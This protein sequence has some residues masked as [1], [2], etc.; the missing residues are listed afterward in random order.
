MARKRDEKII[1]TDIDGKEMEVVI[2]IG[3]DG[4]EIGRTMRSN[5]D[6]NNGSNGADLLRNMILFGGSQVGYATNP[7]TDKVPCFIKV[8]DE[9]LVCLAQGGECRYNHR[10][11]SPGLNDRKSWT[12]PIIDESCPDQ[13]CFKVI[14][15]DDHPD[16]CEGSIRYYPEH[17]KYCGL[18][19]RYC[20]NFDKIKVEKVRK[21]RKTID[22]KRGIVRSEVYDGYN[23]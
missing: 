15:C 19:A 23:I 13:C 3:D 16:D 8:G 11:Y 4:M 17:N 20:R 5:P 10:Y 18:F 21:I 14:V 1:L 7:D 2:E 9:K 22:K 6:L 12:T